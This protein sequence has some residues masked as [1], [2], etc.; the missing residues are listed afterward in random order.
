MTKLC[1][2]IK[3]YSILPGWTSQRPTAN[4]GVVSSTILL[5]LVL[6]WRLPLFSPHHTND[7]A[8]DSAARQLYKSL[9]PHSL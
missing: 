7:V 9:K 6:L 2:N 8:R 4:A 5:D 1:L 3:L